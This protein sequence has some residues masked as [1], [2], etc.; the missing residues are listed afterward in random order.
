MCLTI[1]KKVIEVKEGEVVVEDHNGNRQT[2]KTLVELAAGDFVLSQQ[3][4]VIEKMDLEIAK[5]MLKML[6]NGGFANAR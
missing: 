6:K 1:P 3:N 4:I 2:M 5:E